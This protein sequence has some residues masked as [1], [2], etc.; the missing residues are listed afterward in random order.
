MFLNGSMIVMNLVQLSCTIFVV[1][2][3]FPMQTAYPVVITIV[4]DI[5]C[6]MLDLD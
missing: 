3:I 4:Q 5:L 6:Q 1:E 2:V